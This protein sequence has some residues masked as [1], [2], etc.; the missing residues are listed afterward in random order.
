MQQPQLDAEMV[1]YAYLMLLGVASCKDHALAHADR[2]WSATQMLP[3]ISTIHNVVSS[4]RGDPHE[5]P[6]SLLCPMK[7]PPT[8]PLHLKPTQTAMLDY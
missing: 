5:T 2:S 1:S 8:E 3:V 4:W 6:T 7:Q